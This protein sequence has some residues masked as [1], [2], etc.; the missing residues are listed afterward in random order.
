MMCGHLQTKLK[1]RAPFVCLEREAH[2]NGNG[3]SVVKRDPVL[4]GATML[5]NVDGLWSSC[6][7]GYFGKIASTANVKGQNIA[8]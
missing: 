1:L 5:S 8:L 3:E 6:G 7:P 4:T 2:C